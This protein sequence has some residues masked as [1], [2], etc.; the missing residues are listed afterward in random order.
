MHEVMAV[1]IP[2]GFIVMV[3]CIRIIDILLD[4]RDALEEIE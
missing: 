3:A 4:I 2:I 1:I